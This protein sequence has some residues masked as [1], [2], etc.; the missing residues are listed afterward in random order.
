M[1]KED[2]TPASLCAIIAMPRP[3][4]IDCEDMPIT[5]PRSGDAPRDRSRSPGAEAQA[6]ERLP[7]LRK[8]CLGLTIRAKAMPKTFSKG[9]KQWAQIRCQ[10][11]DAE[12]A[13]AVNQSKLSTYLSNPCIHQ[14]RHLQNMQSV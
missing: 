7:V 2:P 13:A 5:P 10:R 4:P 12:V 8:G 6:A 3:M 14:I 11:A 1:L 9:G